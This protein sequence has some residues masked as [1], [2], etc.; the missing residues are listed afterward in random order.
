MRRTFI[1][2]LGFV[3]FLVALTFVFDTTLRLIF[4][5]AEKEI[6]Y[7]FNAKIYC[8]EKYDSCWFL[9]ELHLANTGRVLQNDI[10]VSV[11]EMPKFVST[12]VNVYDLSAADQRESDP[13]YSVS[14]EDFTRKIS[15][16]EIAPGTLM[17]IRFSSLNV[18][19]K[20]KQ[21]LGDPRIEVKHDGL[22]FEA[23]P[24][25]TTVARVL[26]RIFAVFTWY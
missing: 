4:F 21:N 25:G 6:T 18:S 1:I 5:K 20:M 22:T 23:D 9:G 10:L 17:I 24:R 13:K 2:A 26:T 19:R 12:R 16:Q 11:Y 8:G 3:T 15:I 14:H 7:K